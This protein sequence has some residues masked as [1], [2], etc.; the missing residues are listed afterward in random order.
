VIHHATGIKVDLFVAASVLDRQ[1]LAR[2]WSVAIDGRTW[3]IHSPEDILLQKH[4]WYRKT[5]ESSERQWRDVLGIILVGE[6]SLDRD[7]LTQMAGALQ[8]TDLLERA[9][10][11]AEPRRG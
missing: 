2:R 10:H 1:Q 8:L 4:L 9:W 11:E 3:F 7:Y 6:P 5:G